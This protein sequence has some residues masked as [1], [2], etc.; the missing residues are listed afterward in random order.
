MI[1]ALTAAP[2]LFV[3]TLLG[4]SDGVPKI[5]SRTEK[6]DMGV[7]LEGEE[8]KQVVPIVNAGDGPLDI[9][10]VHTS[11]G[12]AIAKIQN[13]QTGEEIVIDRMKPLGL[14]PL[15][16]LGP[17]E[18][19]DVIVTYRSLG[20]PHRRITKYL[21]VFSNDPANERIRIPIT[22]E[23]KKAYSLSP[24]T[25]KL[26]GIR[27]GATKSGRV[28]FTPEPGVNIQITG[29]R[30]TPGM[31]TE[32]HVIESEGGPTTYAVDVTVLSD[33][34]IGPV[35][36]TLGLLTNHSEFLAIRVP[37]FA[38]ILPVVG[39]DTK[40]PFNSKLV[41]FGMVEKGKAHTKTI[42][43][44]NE[45][46]AVPFHITGVDIES[47]AKGGMTTKVETVE[48]GV[49]YLIHLS[50]RP[51]LATRIF[52]GSVIVRSDHPDQPI[53]KVHFSGWFKK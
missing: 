13:G 4:G 30:P 36:L 42:E 21:D 24:P 12:C 41:D 26:G 37:V 34:K 16:V 53:N 47:K 7:V 43:V 52:K 35:S 32:L 9:M 27:K 48:D 20:Q 50:T 45:N 11:C 23:V 22:V 10:R 39:F 18:H 44:T 8:R 49:R 31:E 28:T 5:T 15:I 19:M 25:L 14:D 3:A 46:P 33:R 1:H 40:N 51:G 6:V 38:E 29:I 2:F 17:D